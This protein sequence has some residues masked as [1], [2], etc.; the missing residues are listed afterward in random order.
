MGFIRDDKVIGRGTYGEVYSGEMRYNDGRVE[1][2]AQKQV[3]FNKFLSGFGILREIHIIRELSSGCSFFP[4]LLDVS[5]GEYEQKPNDNS[6]KLES[7][8]F[9]TEYMDT[10]GTSFFNRRKYDLD[11]A[12]DLCSQLLLGVG[13]M[14]S[15]FITH[16]DIKPGNLLISERNGKLIL[17]ICDFGFAQYLVNSAP[18]TPET[19]TP[20]YRAPEICWSIPKYGDASDVWAVGA[21]IYEIL[22]GDILF[23]DVTSKNP[24]L[25]NVTLFKNILETIPNQW[26]EDVHRMY[27]NNSNVILKVGD[28][29]SSCNMPPGKSFIERFKVSQYYLPREN[30]QWIKIENL[31]CQCFNYNYKQRISAWN[32]LSHSVF[33]K[34]RH[35]INGYLT[36][37][38]KT[39]YSDSI[40][41]TIPE[42][43]NARKILFYEK[44]LTI[45][46]RKYSL[47]R[48]FHSVDLLNIILQDLSYFDSECNVEK[49][50]SACVYFYD[51]FFSSFSIPDEMPLFFLPVMDIRIP[52]P[53]LDQ[54]TA[55]EGEEKTATEAK[56]FPFQ[57]DMDKFYELDRWIFNFEKKVISRVFPTFKFYRPGLFEMPDEYRFTLSYDQ[58]LIIFRHYISMTHWSNGSYRKMFRELYN[59]LID[60]NHVF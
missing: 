1:R 49:V 46:K 52:R 60:R 12:I 32:L 5:F 57:Y 44:F 6:I 3:F 21:T 34:F 45:T 7:V 29:Y 41:F 58:F 9:V 8:T 22:T 30:S 28:S 26:T 20:W 23:C 59:K 48:L 2:G 42:E 40:R 16:R 31:L 43:Y 39:K 18:S 37:F 54:E 17:K 15:K 33:D 38:T 13:Y 35:N 55:T 53:T 10:V 50:A 11:T 47:R 25:D 56:I 19:N 27:K 14:H 24:S 4:R 51:K 36:E